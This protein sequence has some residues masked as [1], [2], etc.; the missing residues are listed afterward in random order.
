MVCVDLHQARLNQ[1]ALFLESLGAA[2]EDRMR[3]GIRIEA[4][5]VDEQRLG[6]SSCIDA[7]THML[8]RFG[9]WQFFFARKYTENLV[10]K[11][12]PAAKHIITN[13]QLLA[14]LSS[15]PEPVAY[16]LPGL[17]DYL[18]IISASLA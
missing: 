1:T 2:L 3:M 12:T 18:R 17:A 5:S 16:S 15:K 8:Q 7:C 14:S 10:A 9:L 4:P 6:V 13:L 11:L